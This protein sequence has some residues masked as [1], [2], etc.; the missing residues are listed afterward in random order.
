MLKLLVEDD[1]EPLADVERGR[2][3]PGRAVTTARL[4]RSDAHP[5]RHGPAPHD[6]PGTKVALSLAKCPGDIVPSVGDDGPGVAP[7][8]A[9]VFV[10]RAGLGSSRSTPGHGL[11]LNLFAAVA[12][13]Q[14]ETA[15]LQDNNPELPSC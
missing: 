12:R 2:R 8:T 14:S 3:E 13:A 4:P 10:A 6:P 5:A 1:A 7:P 11:G 9:S 15:I